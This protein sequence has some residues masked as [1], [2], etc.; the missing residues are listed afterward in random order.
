M[1]DALGVI[2]WA[3]LPY[4]S[5]TLLVAGTIWRWRTDKFGW[6]TRSSNIH[7]RTILRLGS[8]M[9][10][11]GIIF[12]ALG[13]FMG[14]LIPKA[15]T[16]AVGVPQTLYHLTATVGGGVAG[17][18]TVI[19]LVL[20][21]YRRFTVR[22]VTQATT[23]NDRIMYVLL[24]FPIVLGMIAVITHQVLGGEHGYD[25]RETISPWLRGVL[26]LQPEPSIMSTVPLSFQLHVIAAFLLFAIWPFTRLVHAFTPPVGYPTR[27]YVVYRSRKEGDPV[28]QARRGWDKPINGPV[29]VDSSK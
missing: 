26:T 24:A 22:G 16:E 5:L 17:T 2:L 1:S 23:H 9:F 11:F 21:L 15:W 12:V 3:V 27:P 25:Y 18:V 6:T 4:I 10:H 7:E 13:H 29:R 20:L 28:T 14:L 8:P 19:G